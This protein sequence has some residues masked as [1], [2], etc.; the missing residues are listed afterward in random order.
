M[1]KQL[2]VIYMKN[3]VHSHIPKITICKIISAMIADQNF[4]FNFERTYRLRW[5]QDVLIICQEL[6]DRKICEAVSAGQSPHK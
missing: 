6:Y 5:V 1:K 2:P 3:V 4:K